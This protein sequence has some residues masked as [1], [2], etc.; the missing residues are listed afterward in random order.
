M[1]TKQRV[2]E[3]LNP[4]GPGDRLGRAVDG[5][6]LALILLSVVAVVVGTVPGVERR[7]GRALGVFEVVSVVVFSL[8]YVARLWAAPAD[9]RWRP[10]VRGRLRDARPP[11]A[12]VDLL[13]VLPFYL[14]FVGVDL[15]FVRALRLLRLFRL[16]KVGRYVAALGLFAE[17]V[18]ARRAELLL[19]LCVFGLLLVMAASAMYYVEREAQPGAFSSI[20][21]AMWWA[22]VTMTTVGYGDVTPVT[23]LGRVLGVA[24]AVM[25]IGSLALPTAILGA[26]FLEAAERRRREAAGPTCPHCGQPLP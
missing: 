15:R 13:A 14:P 20:P 6:L 18:R 11:L 16:A 24:V 2:W 1:L 25:G 10:A 19:T 7:F 21:A 3:L 17:V 26:G 5:A 9:P 23:A 12:L 22:A 8:E 4:A